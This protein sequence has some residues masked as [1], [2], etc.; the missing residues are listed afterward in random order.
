[1]N[2]LVNY[3]SDSESECE[4]S[5]PSL[6]AISKQPSAPSSPV[7]GSSTDQTHQQPAPSQQQDSSPVNTNKPGRDGDTVSTPLDRCNE[8]DEFV[9]AALKDLQSFAATVD[10]TSNSSPATVSTQLKPQEESQDTSESSRPIAMDLDGGSMITEVIVGDSAS[11]DLPAT[12]LATPTVVLTSEQQHIFDG[13]LAAIDA[14]PLTTKEQSRPPPRPSS[15]LTAQGCTLPLLPSEGPGHFAG[16]SSP[17]DSQ[18]QQAQSVHSVYSRMHQLSLLSSP[19]INQKDIE[20]HLIEFAIR[21]LDWEQGGMKPAY[22]LGEERAQ[23]LA[24]Q[25]AIKKNIDG[26]DGSDSG[27]DVDTDL[28]GDED[29]EEAG[30]PVLMPP[31]GGVVGEM[32]EYMN[33]IEQSAIPKGWTLV[34]DAKEGSYGFRHIATATFSATC[35]SSELLTQLGPSISPTN[36]K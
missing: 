8:G 9:S 2:S 13:F 24:Q 18:W 20:K 30:N 11:T 14:I 3:A 26:Q 7:I 21:I 10:P 4:S 27:M 5:G 23:A 32:L 29:D 28:G 22:F 16:D 34:W 17:S 33:R 19:L 35:P 1:M 15:P 6:I 25:D 12:I 36:S 31:Y